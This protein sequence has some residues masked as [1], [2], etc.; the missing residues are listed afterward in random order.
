MTRPADHRTVT[1]DEAWA[2]YV[3]KC[4]ELVEIE[5]VVRLL[6]QAI[7]DCLQT[8]EPVVM[9]DRTGVY[10]S[11]SFWL[12]LDL[13]TGAVERR[14]DLYAACNYANAVWLA[15]TATATAADTDVSNPPRHEN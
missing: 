13:H 5:L 3:A 9:I 2:E 6:D 11:G 15:A 10:C 8:S 4:K 1:A 7:A 14:A 12:L